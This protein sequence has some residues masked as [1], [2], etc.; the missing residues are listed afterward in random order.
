M[1]FDNELYTETGSV[2]QD[3]IEF[4]RD[5]AERKKLLELAKEQQGTLIALTDGP[6]EIWGAKSASEG[7]YQKT[8]EQHKSI[9]SQLQS[10]D[11][12][13]A[14]YVDKPGADW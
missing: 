12:T 7:D 9:L 4:S 6:V 13:V 2:T 10:R 11:V 3:D 5:I 8:L 1:L 14:G